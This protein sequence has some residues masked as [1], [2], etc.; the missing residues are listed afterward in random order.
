[1]LVVGDCCQ[2]HF[3]LDVDVTL[4]VPGPEEPF[5]QTKL[6]VP[7]EDPSDE[8]DVEATF[9]FL[10]TPLQLVRQEIGEADEQLGVADLHTHHAAGLSP[11]LRL[12]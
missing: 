6:Y 1:M 5:N 10:Q 11:H 3:C 2:S 12:S 7:G 8:L 4:H 9:Y